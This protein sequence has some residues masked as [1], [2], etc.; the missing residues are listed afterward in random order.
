MVPVCLAPKK[1]SDSLEDSTS[2]VEK[3]SPHT[4]F[5]RPT[6]TLENDED[7]VSSQPMK[8]SSSSNWLRR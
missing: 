1:S 3:P 2:G 5:C 8:D 6:H 4:I 7:R